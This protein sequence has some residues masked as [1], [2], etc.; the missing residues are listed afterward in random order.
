MST[1]VNG[2]ALCSHPVLPDIGRPVMAKANVQL[3]DIDW[4]RAVG[5]AIQRAIKRVGL[6]S[7]EAAAKVQ[8]DEGEFGKWLSGTRRPQLD[9]IFAV[10]ELR[11]PLV[12]A[13]A[14]MAGHGVE[15]VTE[16]RITD[17]RSVA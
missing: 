1:R 7:K 2:T 15:I 13:F 16:I 9:R 12:I 11:Q 6:S 10:E 4:M 8:V 17:R 5:L 14:E 3:P